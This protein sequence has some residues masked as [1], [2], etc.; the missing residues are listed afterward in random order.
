MIK[1]DIVNE[2]IKY[3]NK[4][5][6]IALVGS[7]QVGKTTIMQILFS[8]INDKKLFIT[9]EDQEILN[10]F[11][12][13][14]K[15][16]IET[17]IK[18]YDYVF[19]DEFQYSKKGGQKLK[20]IY[21]TQKTKIIISGSSN[22]ELS[23]QSL[24]YLVGRVLIFEVYPLNFG[25]FINYKD[26][27]LYAQYINSKINES[28]IFLFITYFNEFIKYGGYPGVV[29]SD[30][31]E[32][33]LKNLLNTYLLKEVKDILSYKSTHEFEQ[34][35]KILALND[36]TILN[37]SNVSNDTGLNIHKVNEII[38]VLEKTYVIKKLRPFK[39]NKIAE[40]IKSNKIFFMDL[41]FKN[42]LINNFN[43]LDKRH[44]KGAIF[45]SFIFNELIKKGQDLR[46]YNYKNRSEVDFLIR[47]NEKT[48][49][50]EIKSKLNDL[51]ITRSLLSY[52]KKY[53]PNIVYVFNEN[54]YGTKKYEKT[55]VNFTHYL[56]YNLLF[57]EIK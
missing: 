7:R 8:K 39:D 3:Q 2:V 35:L 47:K 44:D 26:P 21:D 36:T 53:N 50:L 41:G 37:K 17:Y 20:F 49:G 13:N 6:I 1:R 54:I 16:F 45:E 19:I 56:N 38:N 11:E 29:T 10:L 25:E 5:E 14:I 43:D 27:K 22:P 48:L 46:F 34:I 42:I 4:K 15:S 31:K 51:K 28:N 57:D 33:I 24:S 32:F 12:N 55:K 9:F 18:N 52:I 30:N 23:I 40:L